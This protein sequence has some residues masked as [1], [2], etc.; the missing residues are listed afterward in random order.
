MEQ[1]PYDLEYLLPA[2]FAAGGRPEQQTH[3]RLMAAALMIAIVLGAGAWAWAVLY[4][5]W[6]TVALT[7]ALWAGA[8]FVVAL[9]SHILDQRADI[10]ALEDALVHVACLTESRERHTVYT[11]RLLASARTA[12]ILARVSLHLYEGRKSTPRA[13]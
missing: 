12:A 13:S 4:A 7:T 5:S 11:M 2:G 3:H 1:K 6:S 10:R 8:V 9:F